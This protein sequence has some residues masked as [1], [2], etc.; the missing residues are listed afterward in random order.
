LAPAVKFLT[1]YRTVISRK[2]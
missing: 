2:R 1:L